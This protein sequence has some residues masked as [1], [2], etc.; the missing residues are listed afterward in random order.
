M[1]KQTHLPLSILWFFIFD[2]TSPPPPK[3]Y[4]TSPWHGV[5]TCKHSRNYRNATSSYSTKTKCD[6]HRWTDWRTRGFQYLPSRDFGAAG[7]NNRQEWRVSP[8]KILRKLGNPP[9]PQVMLLYFFYIST[10]WQECFK[11]D[12]W[13]TNLRILWR[14]TGLKYTP[15]PCD[16]TVSSHIPI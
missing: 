14:W 4:S 5:R 15:L 3:L 12:I 7:D 11:F 1:Q 9:P 2:K 8:T 10:S 6:G 13:Q 16:H